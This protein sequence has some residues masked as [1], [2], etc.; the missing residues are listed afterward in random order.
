MTI[1]DPRDCVLLASIT[2]LSYP[3]PSGDSC[4]T[5]TFLAYM[6]RV[7]APAW[8]V[9]VCE[10]LGESLGPPLGQFPGPKEGSA[11]IEAG[12]GYLDVRYTGRAVGDLTG[13]FQLQKE[14]IVVPN[15]YPLG[16]AA[17]LRVRNVT[18]D[19]AEHLSDLVSELEPYTR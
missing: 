12:I 4:V 1:L 19:M 6:H 2:V 5:R 9:L 14:R 11:T 16:L 7:D 3:D 15:I 17:A 10:D 8:Q 18:R 13:P